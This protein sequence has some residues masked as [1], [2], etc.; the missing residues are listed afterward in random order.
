MEV[1]PDIDATRSG[2]ERES[3]AA[4]GLGRRRRG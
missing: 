2:N 4:S 3:I 1:S